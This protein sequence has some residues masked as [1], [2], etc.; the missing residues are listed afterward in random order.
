[1]S[2]TR[3]FET[4]TPR[5]IG[6]ALILFDWRQSEKTEMFTLSVV[7]LLAQLIFTRV[8]CPMLHG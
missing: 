5:C 6:L 1:M 3:I 4:K 8:R 2:K 7:D